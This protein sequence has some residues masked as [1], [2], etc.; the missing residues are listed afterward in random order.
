MTVSRTAWLNVAR[1]VDPH[2]ATVSARQPWSPVST[3]RH[4]RVS[5]VPLWSRRRCL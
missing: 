5:L 4:V 1:A 2:R 3:P